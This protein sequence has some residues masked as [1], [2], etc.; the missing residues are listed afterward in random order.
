[1]RGKVSWGTGTGWT[2]PHA[3]N[4]CSGSRNARQTIDC[5]SEKVAAEEPWQTAIQGCRGN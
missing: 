5:F 3:L 2:A 1:M 4:L